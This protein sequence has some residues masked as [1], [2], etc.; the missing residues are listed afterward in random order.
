MVVAFGWYQTSYSYLTMKTYVV[1]LTENMDA[2]T[3]AVVDTL[4]RAF[5]LAI[6]AVSGQFKWKNLNVGFGRGPRWFDTDCPAA[7]S[8]LKQ[9]LSNIHIDVVEQ[10]TMVPG[11]EWDKANCISAKQW[12]DAAERSW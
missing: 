6:P 7:V 11:D 4:L 3:E 1:Q 5:A 2:S 8:A 12:E 9:E 10:P